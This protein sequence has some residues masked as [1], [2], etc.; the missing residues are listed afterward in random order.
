MA[1]MKAALLVLLLALAL[2]GCYDDPRVG[3]VSINPDLE[4]DQ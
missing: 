4:L 3:R 2:T 1:S